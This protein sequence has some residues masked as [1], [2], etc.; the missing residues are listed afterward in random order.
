MSSSTHTS[1]VNWANP[2]Q[3]IKAKKPRFRTFHLY[4]DIPRWK[5]ALAAV[6][7][8]LL[9]WYG[10]ESISRYLALQYIPETDFPDKNGIISQDT[11]FTCVPAA[12][13]MFFLDEEIETTQYEIA[14]LAGTNMS[15]TS[16]RGI[17]K[18][19]KYFGYKVAIRDLSYG[20]I[21]R[22]ARPLIIK[23]R[24]EGTL[25]VTYVRPKTALGAME[26]LD[27]IDGYLV[28]RERGFYEYFGKP[29]SRKKCYLFLK[30]D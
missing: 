13:A 5:V 17:R 22:Y 7:L 18:A 3:M 25:H 21:M 9:G 8:F 27:P 4:E 29:G 15:G 19:A 14:R 10:W 16:D 24:H 20:E 2:N 28:V 6:S 11:T 12:M 26:L 23:E 1:A 30:D